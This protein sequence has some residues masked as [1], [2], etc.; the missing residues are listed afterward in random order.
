MVR[1]INAPDHT[2]SITFVIRENPCL[3]RSIRVQSTRV[4]AME[5]GLNG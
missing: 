1:N 5:H 4:M 3:I 2:P